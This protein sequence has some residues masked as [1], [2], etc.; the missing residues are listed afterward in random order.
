MR[1]KVEKSY[2]VCTTPRTGSGFLCD[3]LWR[4]GLF[5]RPDEYFC[6]KGFHPEYATPENRRDFRSY[7]STVKTLAAGANGIAGVKFMWEDFRYLLD[8]LQP[9][10]GKRPDLALVASTFPKPVFLLLS[11]R[12]K[13]HQAMSLYRRRETGVFSS[14]SKGGVDLECPQPSAGELDQLMEQLRNQDEHWRQFFAANGIAPLELVY[15]T[16]LED[17]HAVVLRIARHLDIDLPETF[18]VPESDYRRLS[19]ESVTAWVEA[20]ERERGPWRCG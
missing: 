20:Y 17:M 6:D 4:A 18:V 19:D 10:S 15:E 13:L 1:G 2:L 14:R 5:G 9:G 12:N 11:R 3:T 7:L 8:L 16:M